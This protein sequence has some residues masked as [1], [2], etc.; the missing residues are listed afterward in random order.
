MYRCPTT[1]ITAANII[2]NRALANWWTLF[3]S[4]DRQ[5]RL[6][7]FKKMSSGQYGSGTKLENLHY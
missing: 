5:T 1:T 7:V 3:I 2:A 6:R 4:P